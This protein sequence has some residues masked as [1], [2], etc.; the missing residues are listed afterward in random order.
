MSW[1]YSDNEYLKL[2]RKFVGWEWYQDVS[3]KVLFLHCLLRANWKPGSWHGVPYEAGQFITSLPK[4]SEETGLSIKQ[5][6]TALKHLKGSGEVADKG[7][8]NFRIITVKNWDRYQQRGRLSD[9]QRADEGQAKGNRYK[10][11]RSKEGKNIYF[12]A[13]QER[14]NTLPQPI[15][16]VKKIADGTTRQERLQ[17]L[18]DTYGQDTVLEAIENIKRS[19]F[20]QGNGENGW[21]I[22]FDWFLDPEHF[23]KVLEGN[24]TDKVGQEPEPEEDSW[25]RM[26]RLY[27]ESENQAG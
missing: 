27:R 21:V 23:Q 11:I 25:D 26:W 1:N 20:L 14:W 19:G 22:S 13:V 4:L 10:K 5:V 8:A 7:Q 12:V 16:K 18:I 2:Y 9:S 24:Y 3:T 6:R 15:S 17:D